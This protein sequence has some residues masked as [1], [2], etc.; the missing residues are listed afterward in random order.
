MGMG[1]S[2][3][4]PHCGNGGALFIGVGM[5]NHEVSEKYKKAALNGEHGAEIQKIVKEHP[6]G[7]FDCAEVIY[8]CACGY[9][10]V[11]EKG[12]YTVPKG[13][14]ERTGRPS[15]KEPTLIHEAEHLCPKCGKTMRA[16]DEGTI[17]ELACP[18]CGERLEITK[19]TIL[20]D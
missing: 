15:V 14:G 20:W 4:C 10:T 16:C 5:R 7:R 13:E 2:Y 18:E 19:D 17:P 9:W 8:Q 1:H 6:E 11:E 3:R 12:D